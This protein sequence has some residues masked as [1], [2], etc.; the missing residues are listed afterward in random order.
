MDILNLH[1][2]NSNNEYLILVRSTN[3]NIC[4]NLDNKINPTIKNIRQI[5]LR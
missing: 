2:P 3:P 4:G 5:K 1:I